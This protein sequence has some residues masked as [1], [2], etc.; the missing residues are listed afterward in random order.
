MRLIF[1]GPPGAGKGT[2]ALL[3]M[4]R[5]KVKH[6]SSGNLLRESIRQGD[7]VGKEAAQWMQSGA[8][9]PDDL[10]TGLVLRQIQSFGK[11]GSFVL[12]G[13]PRT[14]EQAEAL[15]EMLNQQGYPPIDL[16]VGFEVSLKMM[17][18]RLAGRRVCEKC[19]ANYHLERLPPKKP[20]LCDRCG[21]SLKTRPD[22]TPD[23][24][25]NRLAVYETQ[26]APL[27]DFYRRQGR[28][29]PVSGELGIEEQYQTLLRLFQKEGLL[30]RAR[31]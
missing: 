19:G 11:D 1:M 8:L 31:G 2:L 7:A 3:L 20:G 24:I 13:F 16:T 10:V 5:L 21:G 6:L 28:L 17:L 4:E 18:V 23:T 14:V 29:R 22:D 25:Q 15:D 30:S 9:V 12:D 27:L 26:T